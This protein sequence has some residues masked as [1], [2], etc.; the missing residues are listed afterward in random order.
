MSGY[1]DEILEQIRTAIQNGNLE[2][3]SY[4]LRQEKCMPYIPEEIELK[5][6][7]LAKDLSYAKSEKI[8]EHEDSLDSLLNKLK[9]KPQSQ[10]SAAEHL[11]DRNLRVCI[12]KIKD[13]LAKDPQPE[14]ASLLIEA[15]AEQE[16]GEEFTL[17]RNGLEFTFWGDAITPLAESTGFLK[18]MKLLEQWFD[19]EPDLQE[20]ARTLVIHEAY[21]YLPLS[22]EED[23]AE[24]LALR[25]AEQVSN[26][27]D[28]GKSYRTIMTGLQKKEIRR[29]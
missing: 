17:I 23:E 22:Y 25:I 15:I 3:A 14:A 24:V 1:Y 26:M 13:Y 7:Q 9:G 21:Q 2:D 4:L 5:L 29:N 6:N 8:P 20:M 19:R 12:E 18:A 27:M 10:L 16:I 11:S 28:D